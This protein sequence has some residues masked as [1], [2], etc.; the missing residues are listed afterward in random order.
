[1]NRYLIYYPF[2]ESFVKIERRGWTSGH[3]PEVVNSYG[4]RKEAQ[5]MI[6]LF[7][8]LK[9]C[10]VVKVHKTVEIIQ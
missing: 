5:G 6:D 9:D 2:F 8:S 10:K 1:M 7:D 3:R 4:S